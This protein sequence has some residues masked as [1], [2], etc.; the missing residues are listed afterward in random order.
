M[1]NHI[2]NSIAFFCD[3]N[4]LTEILEA[5]QCDNDGTN[6]KYGIG[7]ID[8]NKIIPVSDPDDRDDAWNTRCN[9]FHCSFLWQ[10]YKKLR[11]GSLYLP[12]QA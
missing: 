2:H 3:D 10:S 11:I 6:L 12:K 7:T 1:A 4:R 9:A 8:F 5:I